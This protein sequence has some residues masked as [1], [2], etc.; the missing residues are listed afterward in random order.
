[1]KNNIILLLTATVFA[2]GANAGT[3]NVSN[4]EDETKKIKAEISQLKKEEAVIEK[5]V[6]VK[7]AKLNTLTSD[8]T[9]PKIVKSAYTETATKK[10]RKAYTKRQ[11]STTKYKR[12]KNYKKVTQHIN[13]S[14]SKYTVRDYYPT[15]SKDLKTDYDMQIKR[16]NRLKD[17][18]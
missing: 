15:F 16:E 4:I 1:M 5:Q 17:T 13:F 9:K 14:R 18:L 11:T 8:V 12:N 2:V 7:E 3:T 10:K 6:K